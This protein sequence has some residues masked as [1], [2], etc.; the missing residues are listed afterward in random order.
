MCFFQGFFLVSIGVFLGFQVFWVPFGFFFQVSSFLSPF[1]VFFEFRMHLCGK[2]E[3]CTRIWF[4][5]G[6]VRVQPVDA[7]MNSNPHTSGLKLTGDL[8]PRSKL[9]SLPL[10]WWVAFSLNGLHL[11]RRKIDE[12]SGGGK[13][14][15]RLLGTK[16]KTRLPRRASGLWSKT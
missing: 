13:C 1:R 2:N 7:K 5:A 12:V 6:Q 3:T 9:S 10:S 11:N 16:T 4:S 8:K 14:G 15:G